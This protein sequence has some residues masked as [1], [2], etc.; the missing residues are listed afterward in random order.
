MNP[1]WNLISIKHQD[2]LRFLSKQGGIT[3][4]RALRDIIRYLKNEI[5]NAS[6]PHYF[7]E[8][9]AAG[10]IEELIDIMTR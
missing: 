2:K 4:D 1:Y 5:K 9:I 3:A 8:F 7:R 6:R 10:H